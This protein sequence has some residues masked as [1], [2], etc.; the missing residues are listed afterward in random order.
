MSNVSHLSMWIWK[1]L[2]SAILKKCI[3]VHIMMCMNVSHPYIIIII[4]NGP[5]GP[6]LLPML[7]ETF[8]KIVYLQ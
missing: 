4:I 7:S 5:S 1:V 2:A 3:S 8:S 6:D